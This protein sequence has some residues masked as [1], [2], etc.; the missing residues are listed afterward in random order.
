MAY[1][2]NVNTF[3]SD[4][5]SARAADELDVLPEAPENCGHGNHKKYFQGIMTH[6]SNKKIDTKYLTIGYQN[7]ITKLQCKSILTASCTNGN[8]NQ[9]TASERGQGIDELFLKFGKKITI[10]T[11]ND[12]TQNYTNYEWLLEQ[13]VEAVSK[14]KNSGRDDNINLIG[15][16]YVNIKIL[17]D[18]EDLNM[19]I[20]NLQNRIKEACKLHDIDCP[21]TIFFILLRDEWQKPVRGNKLVYEIY[22]IQE[23]CIDFFSKKYAHLNID[24]YFLKED[25]KFFPKKL[26]IDKLEKKDIVGYNNKQD[27]IQFIVKIWNKDEVLIKFNTKDKPYYFSLEPNGTKPNP[28]QNLC[29]KDGNLIKDI[30]KKYV[31]Q[32][33]NWTDEKCSFTIEYYC[34]RLDQIKKDI[35]DFE[36]KTYAGIYIFLEMLNTKGYML[37]NSIPFKVEDTFRNSKGDGYKNIQDLGGPLF[38]CVIK[39]NNKMDIMNPAPR[40]IETKLKDYTKTVIG[41]LH[42]VLHRLYYS[43][44][45]W[46]KGKNCIS[47]RKAPPFVKKD[48][49][50]DLLFDDVKRRKRC[51]KFFNSLESNDNVVDLSNNNILQSTKNALLKSKNDLGSW[52]A[53]LYRKETDLSEEE[54]QVEYIIKQGTCFT[55]RR[56]GR[57]REN[58]TKFKK[59][60]FVCVS[61]IAINILS[62]NFNERLQFMV[63]KYWENHDNYCPKIIKNH[64]TDQCLIYNYKHW[65]DFK[66]KMNTIE[67]MIHNL[68]IK[69]D[70]EF[71]NEFNSSNA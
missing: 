26:I 55:K 36:N 59:E 27:T 15:N 20:I 40:R 61:E 64:S 1:R 25:P 62:E 31:E 67:N 10:L 3:L 46:K 21:K 13:Q 56:K 60:G 37:L 42:S 51:E 22:N 17:C 5:K 33:N 69:S 49:I 29:E 12:T 41:S 65:I 19:K 30:R 6:T 9:K 47:E 44:K 2:N 45:W 68:D 32:I 28:L 63:K 8:R 58:D 16:N 53:K 35:K 18:E 23:R 66:V 7:S 70:E 48:V 14:I 52:Y 38:R 11:Y 34:V 57:A 54:I 71:K 4:E 24:V 50:K 43:K 39:V